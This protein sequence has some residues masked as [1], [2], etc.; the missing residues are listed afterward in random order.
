[1]LDYPWDLS[2]TLVFL[3]TGV[4]HGVSILR[5]RRGRSARAAGAPPGLSCGDLVDINHSVMSLAMVLMIWVSLG[6]VAVWT[7]VVLFGA[8]GLSLVPE[9]RR[10]APSAW[11]IDLFGHVM[12]DAAMMWMLAAMP[13]LMAGMGGMGAGGGAHAGHAEH[14]EGAMNMSMQTPGWADAVNAGFVLLCAVGVLWWSWRGATAR[15]GHR[16]HVLRH[17]MMA[18]GMG[19]MLVLM[20]T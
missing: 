5:R 1:M 16:L 9:L 18:A 20:N 7:Q 11:R 2:L 3:L 19:L 17:A 14:S 4:H 6:D 10:A 12:L 8:L 13:L 15:R